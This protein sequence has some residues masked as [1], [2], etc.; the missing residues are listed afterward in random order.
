MLAGNGWNERVS[1]CS[2]YIGKVS[3]ISLDEFA[4]CKGFVKDT[5]KGCK[6]DLVAL[7]GDTNSFKGSHV[8]GL[9]YLTKM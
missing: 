6:V 3:S 4:T 7:H 2:L 5:M 1:F 8:L 9:R